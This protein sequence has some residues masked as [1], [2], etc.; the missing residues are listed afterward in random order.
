MKTEN[1]FGLSKKTNVAIA[2][3]TA[4]GLMATHPFEQTWFLGSAVLA[5]ALTCI[6][7][8]GFI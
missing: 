3:V 2:S 5:I 8:Q 7:F 4:L 6:I 1:K